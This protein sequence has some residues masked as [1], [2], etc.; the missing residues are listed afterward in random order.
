MN[1]GDVKGTERIEEDD[2]PREVERKMRDFEEEMRRLSESDPD[3][4]KKQGED[5]PDIPYRVVGDRD[6]RQHQVLI[7]Q[8][9]TDC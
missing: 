1:A 5:H 3:H 6:L 2:A 8:G 4:F 9:G 7:K